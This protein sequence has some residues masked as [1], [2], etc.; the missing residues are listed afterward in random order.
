VLR[1]N[2]VLIHQNVWP[3][4]VYVLRFWPEDDHSGS[5][6]RVWRFILEDPSTKTHRGFASL[7][8]LMIFLEAELQVE[9]FP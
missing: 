6:S 3:Y 7:E 8:E 1:K 2:I 9:R 4:F 5:S